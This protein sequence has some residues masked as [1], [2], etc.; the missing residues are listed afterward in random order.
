MGVRILCSLSSCSGL[1]PEAAQA[2]AG[3]SPD[4]QSTVGVV[5]SSSFLS[6]AA[7]QQRQRRMQ[8]RSQTQIKLRWV[9][10]ASGVCMCGSMWVYIWVC[11]HAY[12]YANEPL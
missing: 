6:R 2:A 1:H 10:Q 5:S 3:N 12:L 8:D 11:T 7:N 4:M 9:G